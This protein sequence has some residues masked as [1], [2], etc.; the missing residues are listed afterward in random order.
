MNIKELLEKLDI[1][2][3]NPKCELNYTKDYELLIAVM[4]SAQ[5]TD[6]RVNMV[7]KNLFAKYDL[8]SLANEDL[9]NIK[10][11]IY[12]LGNYNKKA[13]YIKGIAQSLIKFQKGK[14][15]NDRSYLESLPGI[16]RKSA[17]VVLAELF[18]VPTIAVDT[19]VKRVSQRIGLVNS[20]DNVSIIEKKLM[21]KIKK[22]DYNKVN[23][24]LILLGRYICTAKKP[25]CDECLINCRYKKSQDIT[26]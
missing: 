22:E 26:S 12:S 13:L 6:K 3:P 18:N 23:H 2:I 25:K 1:M 10:K 5:C 24:Q 11:T 15:P 4:L 14:V 21:K 7:T 17:N 19:H 8:L 20:N 16:G 9:K